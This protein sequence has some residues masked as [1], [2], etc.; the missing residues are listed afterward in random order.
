M[1]LDTVQF[2]KFGQNVMNHFANA[3][4][5]IGETEDDNGFRH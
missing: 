1:D 2:V 3:V 5:V 4:R